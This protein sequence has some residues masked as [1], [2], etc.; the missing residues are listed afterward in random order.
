MKLLQIVGMG[1]GGL[2]KDVQLELIDIVKYI[3]VGLL[4]VLIFGA[5]K[6]SQSFGA[7]VQTIEATNNDKLLVVETRIKDYLRSQYDLTESQA[8]EVFLKIM[9][10]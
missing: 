5:W 9:T 7:Q 3:G 1:G 2:D 10:K 6:A 4:A 8:H